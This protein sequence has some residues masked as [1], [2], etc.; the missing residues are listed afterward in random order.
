MNPSPL[1]PGREE[2]VA[3]L[4][5]AAFAEWIERLEPAYGTRRVSPEDVR[6]W[7]ATEDSQVWVGWVG[8]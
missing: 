1:E 6:A 7:S 2:I 5:N 3:T 8:D 4:H